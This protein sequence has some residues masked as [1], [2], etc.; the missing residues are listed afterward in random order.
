MGTLRQSP[1]SHQ[2]VQQGP[3]A[4]RFARESSGGFKIAP[5]LA[6]AEAQAV[7]LPNTRLRLRARLEVNG[8]AV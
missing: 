6:A 3:A 2:A 1:R 5:A 8:S 4:D 7:S